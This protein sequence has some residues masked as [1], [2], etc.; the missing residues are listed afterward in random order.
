MRRRIAG[1]VCALLLSLP[2][3]ASEESLAAARELY[4][5]A[6]YDDALVMLN[7]LRGAAQAGDQIVIEQYRAFCLLALGRPTDAQQAIE[8][9]VAAE[10]SYIPSNLDA[11]PRVRSAFTDVRRRMLPGIIQDRYNRAKAAYDR[12]DYA[13]A[14]TE[15]EAVLAA[16]GDPDIALA[17]GRPPLSDIRTL[18]T[19]FHEL[20]VAAATPALPPEPAMPPASEPVV[21]AAAAPEPPPV[22]PD[23]TRTYGADDANVVPPTTLRQ[24]LPEIQAKLTPAPKSGVLEVI[25]DEAGN[26]ESALLRVSIH[27]QYDRQVVDAARGWRYKPATID[28]RPVRYR[29]IV[30]IAL[31]L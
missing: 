27:P 6:A 7:R 23:P 21:T 3:Y 12:K 4:A 1:S 9:V 28:G 16:L 19:G 2:L 17:G 30:T 14:G 22:V 31:K 18:A 26:V 13:S 10:P 29:K 15:F 24:R 20:S 5:A 11:S 25:I 8:A